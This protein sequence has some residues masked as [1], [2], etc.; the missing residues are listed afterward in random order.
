LREQ[1]GTARFMR[2]DPDVSADLV[3]SIYTNHRK[4]A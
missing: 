1:P 3:D 4:L 2:R